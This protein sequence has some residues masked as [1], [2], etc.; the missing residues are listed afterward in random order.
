MSLF[1]DQVFDVL[2]RRAV[3]D[4]PAQANH[5]QV[6]PGKCG[7]HPLRLGIHRVFVGLGEV[8]AVSQ[9]DGDR[10]REIDLVPVTHRVDRHGLADMLDHVFFRTRPGVSGHSREKTSRD[11]HN[12][13]VDI[14]HVDPPYYFR[15]QHDAE[16]LDRQADHLTP[17][18]AR[19][20]APIALP[21]RRSARLSDLTIAFPLSPQILRSRAVE[22]A[23]L[24]P[25]AFALGWAI[26][27]R[28]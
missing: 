16:T 5:V 21:P 8:D 23:V 24:A 11:D 1:N 13:A 6:L 4:L 17:F 22:L 26:A 20:P 25:I 12:S 7:N 18:G 3:K 19:V 14:P 2:P 15:A 9:S 10:E 28:F 27:A